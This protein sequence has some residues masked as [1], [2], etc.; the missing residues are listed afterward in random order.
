M[1]QVTLLI[2]AAGM[3]SRY[4]G[5]KQLDRL[6]PGGG[7]VLDYSV[8]DALRAGF[9]RVVF[10]TR[11]EL[12]DAFEE[13]FV[14]RWR[15]KADCALA[16][17]EL[18]DVPAPFSVP[19]GREKP[20]G[21][22]HAIRAAHHA[23]S[24]PFAVI[25]ADDFYGQNAFRALAGFLSSPDAAS[26]HAMVAYR[27][28]NTLSEH[29]TVSRGVCRVSP[30]GTL[31]GITEFLKIARDGDGA[32]RDGATGTVLPE[33]TPVSMNCWGFSPA[34]FD[35][36]EKDFAS[37]L[38]S[39]EAAA[40]P[41]AEFTIPSVVDGAIA[42]GDAVKVLP[43]DA[44]WSGVTYQSDRPAVVARLAALTESGEYPADLWA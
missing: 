1:K 30:E 3:G 40:N 15:A 43:C 10:V 31:S 28:E 21:T 14:S 41:K 33:G 12:A 38:A 25:N 42:R 22:A 26:P 39:P 16:F 19:A 37:F 5:L 17:Q 20:W 8:F 2:L 13:A 9:S 4:G 29:G 36:L 32:M 7:T 35:A 27:L 34:F 18:S 24:G 44:K 6:G 23:I 11:R